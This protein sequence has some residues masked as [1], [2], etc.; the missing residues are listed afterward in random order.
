[1]TDF[2]DSRGRPR[3]VITGIGAVTPLGLDKE[4]SWDNMLAGRSGISRITEFDVSD[5]PCQ[6]A[7]IV[8]GFDPTQYV[9]SKEAR[10]MSRASQFAVGAALQALDD[11]GWSPNGDDGERLGVSIGTAMGGFEKS[12]EGMLHYYERGLAR[13]SP[14]ALTSSLANM[15]GY[16]VS[17]AV[18]ALGPLLAPVGA[19][20]AGTQGI[21][22]GL[23]MIRRGA[24]DRVLAGGVEGMVMKP[25]MVGFCAM[26]AMPTAYNDAPEQASRPFDADRSGFVLSEG[27]GMVLLERLDDAVARGATIYGEVIG[28]GTCAEA[29][30]MSAPDPTADGAARAMRWA[31]RDAGIAP[32]ELDYINAHGSATPLNDPLETL[33]VKRV[34]G[35]HAYN[36]AVSSTKSIMGHAMGAAGAIELIFSVLALKHGILPPTWN[37]ATPDPDC[38]LDYVPNAPRPADIQVA[39]SN[40]FGLGGQNAC[41]VARKYN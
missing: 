25:A 24:A 31:I 17:V 33:A 5:L 21:G 38:D 19:C 13:T 4:T 2:T 27:A 34:F 36:L 10:R 1:M 12:H 35:E 22:E 6:I 14:F 28:Y 11:A 29:Y 20:A 8:R 32:E 30:H 40:S 23:E 7:G 41:L 18:Q 37:Y 3:V 16:H 39:L 9:N 15:P 26:R